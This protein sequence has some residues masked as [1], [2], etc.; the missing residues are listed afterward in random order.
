MT[1]A[2]KCMKLKCEFLWNSKH[3]KCVVCV[4]RLNLQQHRKKKKTLRK[5]RK[6]HRNSE[7]MRNEIVS[8]KSNMFY[9]CFSRKEEVWDFQWIALIGTNYYFYFEVLKFSS[10]RSFTQQP[11]ADKLNERWEKKKKEQIY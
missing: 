5:K 8:A 3:K 1:M 11:Y 10:F 7:F 6:F 4:Y 9:L 2:A